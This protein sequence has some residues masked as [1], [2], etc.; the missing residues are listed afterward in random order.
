MVVWNPTEETIST[1]LQGAWFSFKPNQMKIM[2]D[3]KCRFIESN[4]KGT[5]LVVLPDQFDKSHERY[6]EDFEK[7]EEGKEIMAQKRSEGISN[8][9]EFHMAIV[10]NNQVSF[11][12]DMAS[13]YPSGDAVKLAALNASKGEL[14]SMRMVAKYKGKQSQNDAKKVEEVQDLMKTIGPFVQ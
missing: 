10:Q 11:R 1:Q 6:V 9:I 4:R 8:L 14:E 2:D 13:R 12:N 3:H 7:S 5:G